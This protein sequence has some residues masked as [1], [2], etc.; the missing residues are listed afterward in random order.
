MVQ[1]PGHLASQQ[2]Y[3]YCDEDGVA[4]GFEAVEHA[5]AIGEGG[6]GL[7]EPNAQGDDSYDSSVA[8]AAAE[9]SAAVGEAER[10]LS[11]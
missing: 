6:D 11:S 3:D 5:D 10:L 9:A 8:A 1:E 4:G 7:E 2:H